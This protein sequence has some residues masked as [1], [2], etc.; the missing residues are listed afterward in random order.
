MLCLEYQMMRDTLLVTNCACED[1]KP[2]RI[3]ACSI[4]YKSDEGRVF[5]GSALHNLGLGSAFIKEWE[6]VISAVC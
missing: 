6:S 3:Y 5:D 4:T 1:D 2:P